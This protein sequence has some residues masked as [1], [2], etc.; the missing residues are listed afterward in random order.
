MGHSQ[1]LLARIAPSLL[2]SLAH[3]CPERVRRIEFWYRFQNLLN[4][5]WSDVQWQSVDS[6]ISR[7]HR[8]CRGTKASQRIIMNS[9]IDSEPRFSRSRCILSKVLDPIVSTSFIHEIFSWS[10]LPPP[11]PLVL[12]FFFTISDSFIVKSRWSF[13][14]RNTEQYS[15]GTRR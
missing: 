12:P 8:R 6:L 14:F 15:L 4:H 1:V 9:W 7:H 10:P 11:L 5:D 13:F 3:F 2:R